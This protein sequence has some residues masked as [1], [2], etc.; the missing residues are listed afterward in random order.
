MFLVAN[1]VGGAR[2][3]ITIDWLFGEGAKLYAPPWITWVRQHDLLVLEPSGKS[4]A[5]IDAATGKR[6]PVGSPSTLAA[7]FKK[8]GGSSA[9]LEPPDEIDPNGRFGTYRLGSE[10]VLLDLERSTFLR[11]GI[12]DAAVDARFSPNGKSLAYVLDHDLYVFDIDSRRSKRLTNDGGPTLLNGVLTWVYWEE[13][14]L[15]QNT[16]YWWSPDSTRIAYFRT[17]E[18]PVPRTTFVG[19]EPQYPETIT[20]AYPKP[21]NANPAVKLGV[22]SATGG[23]TT[24]VSPSGQY[25]YIAG[26]KWTSDGRLLL[27]TMNR[28]LSDTTLWLAD[29]AGGEPRRLVD[30]YQKFGDTNMDFFLLPGDTLIFPSGRSDYEHFYS[31][32]LGRP[33]QPASPV[34]KGPWQ[35]QSTPY[36]DEKRKVLYFTATY[37]TFL[38]RQ[39]LRI[40]SDGTGLT[41]I[42]K[43]RGSHYP[44]FSPDGA[45]Y[46]DSHSSMEAPDSLTLHSADGRLLHTLANTDQRI[47]YSVYRSPARYFTIAARDGFEM[48]AL[49]RKPEGMKPGKRYP[50]ILEIYGGPQAPTVTDSFDPG[51]AGSQKYPA[52][53]FDQLFCDAGYVVLHVDNR[54]STLI[55]RKFVNQ[56]KGSFYGESERNDFVDAARWLKKQSFIDPNRIGITGWSGGGGNTLNCMCRSTEF[57]AGIAGAPYVDPASYDTVYSEMLYGLPKD[58]PGGYARAPIWKDAKNLHGKLLLVWGTGDDNVHPQHEQRFV[59]ACIKAGK[60]IQLMVYPMR[61]HGFDD[62]AAQKHRI[63]TYLEFWKANL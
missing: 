2:K 18:S 41:R 54:S 8:L 49:I 56:T 51:W 3:P 34:T 14:F 5:E 4:F 42:S 27:Q 62:V 38:E 61:K 60:T 13:I 55:S 44:V 47:L 7:E 63:K 28:A 52:G 35:I 20:Q 11:T 31:I 37:P 15:H 58:N 50:A 43:E 46:F 6:R 24:W 16:A 39:L 26:V 45:Y 21:G 22:I 40:R 17:D 33:S 30:D 9:R 59:D 12:K 10:L 1:A 25:E 36:V 23:D 19:F 53:A 29:L 48:P 32:D 57:K